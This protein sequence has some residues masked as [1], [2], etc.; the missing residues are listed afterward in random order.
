[1]SLHRI[2]SEYSLHAG[3]LTQEVSVEFIQR[4]S[5]KASHFHRGWIGALRSRSSCGSSLP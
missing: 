2:A 1:M 5:G 3:G 4:H